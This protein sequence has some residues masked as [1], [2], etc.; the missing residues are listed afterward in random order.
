MKFTRIPRNRDKHKKR[1]AAYCRVSTLLKEQEESFDTQVRY[2]TSFIQ[3]HQ[4]WEFVGVYS[5]EKSGTKASNRPGFRKLVEDALEGHVDCIICKSLSRWARNIVDAQYYLNILHGNGVDVLFE[6]EK[7]YTGDPSC[8]ML[9]SFLTA[10]AQDESHSIS[11]NVKWSYRAKL[12]RGEYNLG[13]NRVLGY[14]CVDGKLV[15]NHNAENVRIIYRLY[16]EGHCIEEIRRQLSVCGVLTRNGK[17]LSHS[18]ILY[19]L[20]NETY[21]GDKLLQKQ[22]PRDFLTKKPITNMHYESYYLKND[23]EAIVEPV[24]W[25][26][27]QEKLRQNRELIKLVGHPGGKPH[28]LYGKVFC[29][30]CGSPMLRRT[31]T[32][33]KGIKH[34]SWVCRNRCNGHKKGGCRMRIVR[35]TYLLEEIC[36]RMEW[37][38]FDRERFQKDV[39]RVVVGKERLEVVKRE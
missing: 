16:L 35:E 17:P 33:H 15:P 19:I 32:G 37:G 34:K 9:L 6:K 21:R 22:P 3:S 31:F 28:F 2:Y 12:R 25:D 1:V 23:H 4:D 30:D 14:D 20:K 13:N 10:I 29:A 5:D 18:N 7:L 38:E 26:A 8:A 27:V 24:D 36:A 11:E 39:R